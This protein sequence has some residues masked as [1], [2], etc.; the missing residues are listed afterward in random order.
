MY[1]KG[2][3]LVE[4]IATLL[5][6]AILSTFIGIKVMAVDDTAQGVEDNY[7]Q[8]AIDRKNTYLEYISDDQETN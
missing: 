5:I 1:N 4:L 3:T 8:R 2:F 6:V 7:V